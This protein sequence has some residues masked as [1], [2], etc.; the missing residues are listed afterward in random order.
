[1]Y[2]CLSIIDTLVLI[3]SQI[4][5]LLLY[6]SIPGEMMSNSFIIMHVFDIS[7]VVSSCVCIEVFL[8]I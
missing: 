1:M 7:V 8:F 5:H 2:I 3:I 4:F 6:T